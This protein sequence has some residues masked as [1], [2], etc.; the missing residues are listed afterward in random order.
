MQVSTLRAAAFG[1]LFSTSFTFWVGA[2]KAD[3]FFLALDFKLYMSF[4]SATELFCSYILA[5]LAARLPS[6]HSFVL[7]FASIAYPIFEL[8]LFVPPA[9]WT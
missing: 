5:A 3:V 4:A 2:N 1:I 7:G 8:F 9:F 6:F